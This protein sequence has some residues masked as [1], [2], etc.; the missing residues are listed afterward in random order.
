MVLFI[1]L[2]NFWRVGKLYGFGK[3]LLG[4]LENALT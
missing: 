1:P 3:K 4:T 2:S